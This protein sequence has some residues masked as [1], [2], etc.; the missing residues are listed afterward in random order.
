MRKLLVLIIIVLCI[1]PLWA[2]SIEYIYRNTVSS[3]DLENPERGMVYVTD[4]NSI[5]IVQSVN[6]NAAML[7]KV[8]TKGV[9]EIGTPLYNRPLLATVSVS[10]SMNRAMAEVSVTSPLYPVQ[11]AVAAGYYYKLKNPFAMAGFSL[12]IPLSKVFSTSFTLLED[13]SIYGFAYL[14]AIIRKPLCFASIYGGGY[15]H[16]IGRFVWGVNY[17]RMNSFSDSLILKDGSVSVVLGV[18][19]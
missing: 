12:G 6:G 11:P 3:T 18:R 14:G 4:D 17:S 9:P 10:A 8:Y 16:S 13:A 1:C 2:Q 15:S 5:Y 7:D 19:F